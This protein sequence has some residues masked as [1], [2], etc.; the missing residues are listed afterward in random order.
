MFPGN[1]SVFE[2][3]RQRHSCRTYAGTPISPDLIDPLEKLIASPQGCPFGS[4]PRF[5]LVTAT[6]LDPL[7]LRQ[8]GTYGFIKNPAG[9]IIGAVAPG[10][11]YLEDFGFAMER[12]ILFVTSQGLGS[13]WLGGSFARSRFAARMALHKDEMIPAVV[14]IGYE[15]EDNAARRLIRR[16]AKADTRKPWDMLFFDSAFANPLSRESAGAYET[17][18][19]MVRLAPSASNRQPWRIIRQG[20]LF[21]FYLQRTPGYDKSNARIDLLR[22]ADL[23]RV[24][25]G[26]AMCHFQLTA[27]ELGL[28]GMWQVRAPENHT[29]DAALAYVASWHA[30]E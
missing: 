2:L 17:P 18:L 14:A 19:E 16:M 10:E 1:S 23:Q 7:A 8:L 26:I 4:G 24:D 12:I 3:I 27:E 13:C 22:T 5:Q 30:A 6:K 11:K 28:Q 9:F 29:A 21:H 20:A 25:V 15:S